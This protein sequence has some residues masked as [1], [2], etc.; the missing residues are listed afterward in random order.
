MGCPLTTAAQSPPPSQQG[1]LRTPSRYMTWARSFAGPQRLTP[2]PLAID[3]LP[4][5][6]VVLVSHNH[7]DHLDV[8][9]VRALAA[10]PGGRVARGAPRADAAQALPPP[11]PRA[12]RAAAGPTAGGG[13]H[14]RSGVGPGSPG[15]ASCP[16]CPG[17][18]G[19]GPAC[20][21]RR[22]GATGRAGRRLAR[23]GPGSVSWGSAR[24][25]PLAGGR[26]AAPPSESG[27]ARTGGLPGQCRVQATG[28][29]GGTR[30]S[31]TSRLAERRRH[32][33]L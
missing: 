16:T 19:P 10:Q 14:G 11:P 24:L 7:Y 27:R 5:I 15:P 31:A 2:A 4:H 23:A 17:P 32:G 8:T 28:G 1:V 9:T 30:E 3:Q 20:S 22:P 29:A 13:R 18:V 6:D 26:R 33:C 25:W 21:L 12:V